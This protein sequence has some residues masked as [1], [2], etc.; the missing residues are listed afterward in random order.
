MV[1]ASAVLFFRDQ[2]SGTADTNS[3]E[4]RIFV[5][6]GLIVAVLLLPESLLAV[7]GGVVV[8]WAG[9]VTLLP[10]TCAAKNDFQSRRD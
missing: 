6:V 4:F 8:C 9:A 2:G 3:T 7:A 5:L 10:F 1:V